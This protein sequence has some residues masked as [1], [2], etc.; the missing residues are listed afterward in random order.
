MSSPIPKTTG[1]PATNATQSTAT[2][3]TSPTTGAQPSD[4]A[5][6]FQ[7]MLADLYKSAAPGVGLVA[8]VGVQ[9]LGVPA[10]L[11]TSIGTAATMSVQNSA[12]PAAAASVQGAVKSSNAAKSS[13]ESMTSSKK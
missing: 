1:S 13:F 8:G 4:G 12:D 6:A 7:T 2:G 5:A 11:A 3:T 10:P 9:M